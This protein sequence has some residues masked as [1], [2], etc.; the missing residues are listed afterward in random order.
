MFFARSQSR[1]TPHIADVGR[2]GVAT[3]PTD[4]TGAA[5]ILAQPVRVVA[6]PCGPAAAAASPEVVVVAALDVG[7]VQTRTAQVAQQLAN[8]HDAGAT[9]ETCAT[10]PFHYESS[11]RKYIVC[12]RVD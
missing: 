8:G 9:P 3:L 6:V 10:R 2:V 5:A 7:P 12:F 4:R 11:R 1:D